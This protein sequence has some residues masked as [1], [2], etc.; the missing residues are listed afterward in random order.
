MML[1]SFEPEPQKPLAEKLLHRKMPLIYVLLLCLFIAGF[2]FI[3]GV[4]LPKVGFMTLHKKGSDATTTNTNDSTPNSTLPSTGES[5]TASIVKSNQPQFLP[6]PYIGVALRETPNGLQVVKVMPDSPAS[7]AGIQIGDYIT[8][9]S[10]APDLEGIQH[11]AFYTLKFISIVH[12]VPSGGNLY[13]LIKRDG[14]EIKKNIP[15]EYTSDGNTW[16]TGEIKTWDASIVLPEIKLNNVIR[17]W[18]ITSIAVDGKGYSFSDPANDNIAVSFGEDNNS[19]LR[20][21]PAET[22]LES[23]IPPSVQTYRKIKVDLYPAVV[24][25]QN[26]ENR[27]ETTLVVSGSSLGAHVSIVAKAPQDIYSQYEN[28]FNQ[29]FD[30]LRVQN[31]N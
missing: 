5:E 18:K 17:G 19:S 27:K 23:L 31:L 20:Y 11:D 6:S 15:I 30:S 25:S 2:S 4:Y 22:V 28:I 1:T 13:L 10:N 8:K 24:Y 12:N 16:Y 9:A 3:A 7:K 14:Q 29:I 26:K 21:A